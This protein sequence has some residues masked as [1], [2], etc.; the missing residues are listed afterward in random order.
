MK[1]AKI[2]VVFLAS[3]MAFAAIGASL[4]HWEETL[5][6]SGVMTTDDI[7]PKFECQRSNDPW[8]LDG[9]NGRDLSLDPVDCG[10]WDG[11]SWQSDQTPERRDKDV[12]YMNCVVVNEGK[13]INIIIGD[14]Y[15]CYYSHAFWCVTNYGSCP[16][17]IHSVQLTKVSIQTDQDDDN[18]YTEITLDSPVNLLADTTYYVDYI[19]DSNTGEWSVVVD[20]EVNNPGDY[21]YSIMPTGQFGIDTQLDPHIWGTG[22]GHMQD[23]TQYED[24][25]E[26]DMCIHFENGCRQSFKYDFHIDLVFYNWPEYLD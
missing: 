3:V 14:A 20:P 12:G 26:Q 5:T 17:L 11:G 7:D 2:G 6:I 16:V 4:A 10:Y 22:T 18:T 13:G 8:D 23:P 9:Q 19:Q 1:T 15:P 24:E 21:D 25:L